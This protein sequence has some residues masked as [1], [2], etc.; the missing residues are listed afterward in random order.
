MK[1]GGYTP[2]PVSLIFMC[3]VKVE[4]LLWGAG[5]TNTNDENSVV[6]WL[7]MDTL[8]NL[9]DVAVRA[10][11]FGRTLVIPEFATSTLWRHH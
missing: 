1:R 4:G 9:R 2:A 5:E 10:K 3:L 7:I 11:T 6:A 8:Q